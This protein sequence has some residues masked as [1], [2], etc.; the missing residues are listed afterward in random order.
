MKI[1]MTRGAGGLSQASFCTQRPLHREASTQNSLD[2]QSFSNRSLCTQELLHRAVFTHTLTYRLLY[3][4]A[5][6]HRHFCSDKT[7]TNKNETEA[8]THRDFHNCTQKPSHKIFDTRRSFGKQKLWH[9]EAFTHR[10][11]CSQELF[12]EADALIRSRL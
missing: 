10:S 8:C 5:F 11:L 7:L 4:E 9:T 1:R 12:Q 3:T 2:A 6:A